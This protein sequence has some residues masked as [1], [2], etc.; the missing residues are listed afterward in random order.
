M[1]QDLLQLMNDYTTTDHHQ[2]HQ[3]LLGKSKDNLIAMLT[4]LLT[5]YFND[6]NSSTPREIVVALL[7]GYT[8]NTEKLGYNGYRQNTLT[9]RTEHCEIKP[10]NIRTDSIAKNPPKLNGGGNFTDYT[11]KRL[12]EDKSE[13]PT[14]LVAGFVDGRLVHIFEFKFNEPGFTGELARQLK[15]QFPQGDVSGRFLR[16]ASF[17]FRHFKEVKSLKVNFVTSRS[18]L[19]KVKPH[20]SREVFKY[21]HGVAK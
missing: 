1:N 13:N 7:S 20:I 15:R 11:W 19:N 9:G 21:L 14:M 8:P 2:V 10:K 12:E 4:D 5:T 6:R 3:N 18:E 17:T 16:S